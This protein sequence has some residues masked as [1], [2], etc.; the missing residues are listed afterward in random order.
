MAAPDDPESGPVLVLTTT[1]V[2][3]LPVARSLLESA[4]IPFL[5]QG[6]HGLAQLPTGPLAGPFAR[7]GLATRIF[8]PAT[9]AAA[10]RAILDQARG[11]GEE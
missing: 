8:V 6:E 4:G 10:A 3:F 1:D 9:H 5:V 2:D 7:A 11:D